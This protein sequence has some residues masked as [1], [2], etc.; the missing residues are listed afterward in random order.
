MNS[1]IFLECNLEV[2]KILNARK[3]LYNYERDVRTDTKGHNGK[4]FY[5]YL[6]LEQ[7]K[8]PSFTFKIKTDD[9]QK[10]TRCFWSNASSRQAYKFYGDVII[11]DTRYNTNRQALVFA[12]IMGVNNHGQTIIF[13][14]R[15]LN[16][17]SK[18]DFI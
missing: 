9:E 14:C 11:F 3:Y 8:N 7:G 1:L 6:K 15:F 16:H 18:D 17:E 5:E 13:R 12:S 4:M 2:Q 10:I